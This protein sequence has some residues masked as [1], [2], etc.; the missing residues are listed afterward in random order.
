MKKYSFEFKIELEGIGHSD[1][2]GNHISDAILDAYLEKDPQATVTCE[3]RIIS[4]ELIVAGEVNSSA[5]VDVLNVAFEV[6]EDNGDNRTDRDRIGHLNTSYQKQS[7]KYYIM[8]TGT[9]FSISDIHENVAYLKGELTEKYVDKRS[10]FDE[11][12]KEVAASIA[13]AVPEVASCKSYQV[14]LFWSGSEKRIQRIIGH[15]N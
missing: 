13:H 1:E 4:N 7:G 2:V 14:D 6:L 9:R 10:S 12:S 5:N 3:C 11:I 15:H 8:H